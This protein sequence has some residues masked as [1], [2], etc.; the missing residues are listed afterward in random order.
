MMILLQKHTGLAVNPAELSS[1]TTRRSNGYMLLEVKMRNGSLH[2]VKH[3]PECADGD[4]IYVLHKQL[5]EA[6]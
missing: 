6:R 4:D 1:M 2:L 5:L 3:C